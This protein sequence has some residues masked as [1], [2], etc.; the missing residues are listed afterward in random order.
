MRWGARNPNVSFL[1]RLP[2]QFYQDDVFDRFLVQP[3]NT[4]AARAAIW[5]SQL[6]YE[7][8]QAKIASILQQWQLALELTFQRPLLAIPSMPSTGGLI[9]TGHETVFIAFQGTDPLLAANWSTNF[10]FETDADGIHSG[11]RAALDAVW[12]D[13][14]EVLTRVPTSRIILTGHSLGGALA[15]LCAER[16]ESDL[17]LKPIAVYTFGMPR[18]GT[19]DFTRQYNRRL[20]SITFRFIHGHDL[21]PTVPPSSLGFRHVGRDISCGVDEKFDGKWLSVRPTDRPAFVP[22]LLDRTRLHLVRLVSGLDPAR[23]SDLLGVLDRI[24]PPGIAHHL[25]HRYWRALEPD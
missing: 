5:L 20:G 9:V 19:T 23:S 16:M 15:A 10:R 1:V 14:K 6:A 13:V 22:S 8:D 25:P 24:L 2:K 7:D 11:F 21:V 17:G 18:V 3:F 12:D 4:G